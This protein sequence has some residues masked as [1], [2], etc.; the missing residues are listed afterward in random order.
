MQNFSITG[1][2]DLEFTRDKGNPIFICIE[3]N[4]FLPENMVLCSIL[5]DSLAIYFFGQ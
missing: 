2:A 4:P 1:P 5:G 3:I